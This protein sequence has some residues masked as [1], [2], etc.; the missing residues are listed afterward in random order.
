MEHGGSMEVSQSLSGTTGSTDVSQSLPVTEGSM[1]VY[2]LLVCVI[3]LLCNLAHF[4]V[5]LS[6]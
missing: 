5:C 4:V 6:F 1:N 2:K 3:S